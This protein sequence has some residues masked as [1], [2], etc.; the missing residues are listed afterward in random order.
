MVINPTS[1][2]LFADFHRP[3]GRLAD[4][5]I[6]LGGY[7]NESAGDCR[8]AAMPSLWWRAVDFQRQP[9]KEHIAGGFGVNAGFGSV[10]PPRMPHARRCCC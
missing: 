7:R 1:E 8:R 9:F 3:S 5:V 10:Q 2:L 4:G 6:F